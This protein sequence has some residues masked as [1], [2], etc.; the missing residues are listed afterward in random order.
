MSNSVTINEFDR[1]ILY[2]LNKNGRQSI[3]NIA[4]KIGKGVDYVI[5][6]IKRLKEL[7]I[8][9]GDV[10]VM[11]ISKLGFQTHSLYLQVV[12]QHKVPELIDY[13]KNKPEVVDIIKVVGKY[14]LYTVIHVKKINQLEEVISNLGEHFSDVIINYRLLLCY[15]GYSLAHNYLFKNKEP[16]LHD[17]LRYHEKEINLSDKEMKFISVLLKDPRASFH[18]IAKEIDSTL[19]KVRQIYEDLI[20]KEVI[21][22]I[23][24][25][26]NSLPLGYLHKHVLIRL[27]FGGMKKLKEIKS[28]LLGMKEIKALTLTFGR[29]DLTGRFIFESLADFQQFQEDFY[30]KF[31]K[32]VHSLHADDYFEEIDYAP[33][34]AIDLLV[35][36]R[37]GE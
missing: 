5:Y 10:V 23:R 15:N 31:G 22:Y 37:E 1:K 30:S 16:I 12:N 32:Y 9:I 7:G 6:R 3:S 20:K 13:L 34:K 4:Q 11:D 17:K 26:L 8:Y 35:K 14:Q 25:S 24:P 2:E 29:Y 27:K 18:K 33:Q 28:H 36:E 19:P 21:Y